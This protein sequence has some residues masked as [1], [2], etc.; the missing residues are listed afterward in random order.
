MPTASPI[1][2]P[3]SETDTTARIGLSPFAIASTLSA[4][5]GSRFATCW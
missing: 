3:R 5:V 2:P 1:A 4:A